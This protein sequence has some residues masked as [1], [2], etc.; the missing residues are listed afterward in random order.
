MCKKIL[1]CLLLTIILLNIVSCKKKP[2]ITSIKL[3]YSE[4]AMDIAVAN[5]IRAII[6]QQTNIKVE[7]VSL[8]D[9]LI[10]PS[11]ANGSVD[12]TLSVLMPNTHS[13]LMKT[14]RDSIL[15][16]ADYIDDLGTGLYVPQYMNVHTI[17][18]LN[19]NY[20]LFKGQIFTPDTTSYLNKL[21]NNAINTYFL[22]NY[23]ALSVKDEDTLTT[24]LISKYMRNENFCVSFYHPHWLFSEIKLKAL[25][26]SKGIF[27][28][29]EKASIYS[30]KNL[31]KD[32]PQIFGFLKN[33]KFTLKDIE[34]LM[35]EN[36]KMDSDPKENA[37][38][39][40]EGN[41]DRV[42]LWITKA[43]EK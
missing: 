31:D 18:D 17:D 24:G 4:Y 16:I 33:V 7:M 13:E 15:F 10:I 5:V 41:I 3:A 39:W 43:G 38:K 36:R 9:S 20:Q 25:E 26:D 19:N 42:N 21:A 40:I 29:G 35:K 11:L 28:K 27:G 22:A 12:L 30:R 14:Y 8:P 6:D 32:L 37:M 23:Q 1:Y 34:D 2:K